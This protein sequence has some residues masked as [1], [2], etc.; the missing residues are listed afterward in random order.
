MSVEYER[1]N[2]LAADSQYAVGVG[3]Q[4]VRCSYR[5]AR[6]WI[7]G[8]RVLEL[9]PAEGHMTDALVHDG[10]DL[11]V[12][13]GSRRFCDEIAARHPSVEVVHSIFEDFA[14]EP[15]FN[16]V[17]LGHVV[18]HVEDPVD[19]LRL[20]RGW[21]APGGR[22]FAAVPNARSLHRQ[23]AV[24]MG[25]LGREDELNET[26]RSI[27]HRRVFNPESFRGV[28]TS[29]GLRIEFFGGYWLKPLSSGQIEA[30]WTPE[31]VDAFVQLG[32]R[33]PDIAAEIYV[34]AGADQVAG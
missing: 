30:N 24:V 25:L 27:G 29:A 32:E 19:I 17:V 26:D 20:V 18:E 16:T 1:L 3:E 9:G 11:T 28:F 13:E 23:A 31:M 22:I 10:F 15:V 21:L 8:P 12:V 7:M 33:Y 34:V 14:S 4:M 2:L 6:R 5:V